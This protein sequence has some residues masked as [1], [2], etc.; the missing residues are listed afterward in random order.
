MFESWP[1]SGTTVDQ[2]NEAMEAAST[3]NRADED[4]DL[5]VLDS[6][7]K[8]PRDLPDGFKDEAMLSDSHLR[9]TAEQEKAIMDSEKEKMEAA[10]D[11]TPETSDSS[12]DS[13]ESGVEPERK[14]LALL[15]HF[16][17][18]SRGSGKVH[19]PAEMAGGFVEPCKPSSGQG[20]QH[21]VA[22]GKLGR[23][24]AL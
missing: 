10:E 11:S 15:P 23:L 16:L 3:C 13:D 7:L 4:G 6:K 9:E 19:K 20:V 24:R 21:L 14:D 17:I 1:P 22:G 8:H 5:D 12:E 18:S 2:A